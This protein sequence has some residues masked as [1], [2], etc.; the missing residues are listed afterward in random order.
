MSTVK[1]IESAIQRLPRQDFTKLS[2]W[3]DE[4]RDDAWDHQIKKDAE[5]CRLDKLLAQ[6]DSDIDA[7]RVT[8]FPSKK[9]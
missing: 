7:G 9:Q 5:S 4:Y 2:K 6:V 3:F 8:D 1:E